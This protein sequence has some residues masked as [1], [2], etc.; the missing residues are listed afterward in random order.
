MVAKSQ[1]VWKANGYKEAHNI[2]YPAPRSKDLVHC[3]KGDCIA[4]RNSSGAVPTDSPK[5]TLELLVKGQASEFWRKR[6][7][8]P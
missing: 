5:G 4:G 3:V 1:Q 6:A 8:K 2:M 7:L